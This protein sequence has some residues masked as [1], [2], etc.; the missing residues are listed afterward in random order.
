M[1]FIITY[2]LAGFILVLI[3]DYSA[4]KTN[5]ENLLADREKFF[6]ALIW[7]ISLILFIYYIIKG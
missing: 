5:P 7:P 2:L 3:V 1:T 6:M 4:I